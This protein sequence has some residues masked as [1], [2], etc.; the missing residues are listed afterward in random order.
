MSGT[1]NDPGSLPQAEPDELPAPEFVQDQAGVEELLSALEGHAAIG[2]DTEA[3]S[4]YSYREKVCLIQVTA[5][6]RDFLLDPFKDLDLDGLAA[7]FADPGVTKIF[8]DGEFDVTILGREYGWSFKNLFDTRVAAAALGFASPGLAAVL[9]RYFGLQLDKS[10]Q[11]SDW[12]RRPLSDS[13]IAY[14]R[15]DTRYLE[16]L[17]G[18]MRADLEEQGRTAVVDGECR[19]LSDMEVVHREFDP[20]AYAK[21]KGARR[22]DP[23][24][25]QVLRELFILRDRLAAERD[26]PPFKVLGNEA[27]LTLATRMPDQIEQLDG[28]R[29]FPR[30]RRRGMGREVLAAIAEGKRKGPI[31]RGPRGP[32]KG[33]ADTGKRLED[34]EFELHERLREWRRKKADTEN[35]DAS[36]VLNRHVMLRLAKARPKSI[37]D[38]AAVEGLLEWQVDSYG[39]ALERLM[40][41]FERELAAGEIDFEKRRRRR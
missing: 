5:G 35:M 41:R 31:A 1:P 2:V 15:L 26:V 32:K 12:S 36:L 21:I 34:P 40:Q 6:D 14:A 11:R 19:R 10:E 33:G 8:H 39:V 25:S 30:G 17:M 24:E 20:E 3:D 22:L 7:V 9:E 16:P 37:E 27:L 38:L 28:V 29:G 13:Q 4:F 23:K 18:H